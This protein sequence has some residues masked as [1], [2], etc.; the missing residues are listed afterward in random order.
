MKLNESEG[1]DEASLTRKTESKPDSYF[2]NWDK[3]DRRILGCDAKRKSK[4]GTVKD[5]SSDAHSRCG[6]T[7][8]SDE[9]AVMATERRGF[10][11]YTS[12]MKQP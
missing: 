2:P 12:E 4:R 6:K 9:R 7:R 8:S 1:Y 11:V 10:V 3:S 5:E